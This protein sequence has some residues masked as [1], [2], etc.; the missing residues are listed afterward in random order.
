MLP[1]LFFFQAEDG[2]RDYKVTGGSDVC[3]SDL[4]AFSL[5][6]KKFIKNK[7]PLIKLNNTLKG[8]HGR[9]EEKGKKSW[10]ELN[11]KIFNYKKEFEDYGKEIPYN[12]FIIVH[13]IGHCTDH[14]ER[15][16]YS[17]EWQSL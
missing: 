8:V 16:S 9:W 14:V 17:K 3:S 5:F 4:R 1:Y 12:L 6:N 10:M 15:T 13:E 2:I 7:I 11:P